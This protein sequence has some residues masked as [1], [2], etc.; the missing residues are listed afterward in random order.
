MALLT[1]LPT[2]WVCLI[3]ARHH[4]LQLASLLSLTEQLSVNVQSV[5]SICSS[6][7]GL[8]RGSALGGMSAY[9]GRSRHLIHWASGRV[10]QVV[11]GLLAAQK[12]VTGAQS[13]SRDGWLGFLNDVGRCC[14]PLA[15]PGQASRSSAAEASRLFWGISPR[16][17]RDAVLQGLGCSSSAS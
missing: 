16:Q 8:Q 4:G 5:L 14:V 1:C 12:D 7:D 2:M 9:N 3:E 13:A 15:Q 6:L 10:V 11:Q 17:V